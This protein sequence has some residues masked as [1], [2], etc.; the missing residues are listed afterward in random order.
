MPLAQRHQRVVVDATD[1]GFDPH[2]RKYLIALVP[3][4]SAA[5]SSATQHA[6][7]FQPRVTNGGFLMGKFP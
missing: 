4:Q 5:L 6:S 7:R 1:S 2:S 3:K